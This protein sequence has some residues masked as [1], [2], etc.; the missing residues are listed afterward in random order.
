MTCEHNWERMRGQRQRENDYQERESVC[1]CVK[2]HAT[3]LTLSG[4]HETNSKTG[5]RG[6]EGLTGTKCTAPNE[7]RCPQNPTE[8]HPRWAMVSALFLSLQS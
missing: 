4:D 6:A 3:S 2:S 7:I 1:V 5:S 8:V